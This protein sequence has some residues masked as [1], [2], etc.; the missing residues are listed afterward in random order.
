MSNDYVVLIPNFFFCQCC[1]YSE[2]FFLLML[3][4]CLPFWGMLYLCLI[5][6]VEF[7]LFRKCIFGNVCLMSNFFA[8]VSLIPNSLSMF[9]KNPLIR[10]NSLISEKY[11][12]WRLVLPGKLKN[13]KPM[14]SAVLKFKIPAKIKIKS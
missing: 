14:I 4:L 10:N 7:P 6:L 1:T 5:F 11:N 13:A 12:K 9:Y 8:G 2:I 3:H